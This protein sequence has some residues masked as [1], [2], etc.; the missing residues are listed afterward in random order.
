VT[1]RARSFG[2]VALVTALVSQHRLADAKVQAPPP[3]P[4]ASDQIEVS[5]TELDRCV[6]AATQREFDAAIE[7]CTASVEASADNHRAWYTLGALYG[8]RGKWSEAADAFAR[9]APFDAGDP[10]YQMS[11][12]I[13]LYERDVAQARD[14]T[15][16]REGR[17]AAEVDV[18]LATL[19]FT[20]ARDRL[21]R[22]VA[23]QPKL[24]RAHSYLGRI[25][26]AGGDARAAAAALSRAIEANPRQGASYIAL[27][28]LYRRW[29]YV[30][31][32]VAVATLGTAHVADNAQRSELW[33]ALGLAR[34][35]SKDDAGAIDAY[36]RALE[37]DPAN[38]RA[39]L[40][41]G[42]AAY[43]KGELARAKVDLEA[44][45]KAGGL[46]GVDKV[47][48]NRM[49]LDIAAKQGAKRGK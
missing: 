11:L 27:A 41:R 26:R 39:L 22:A 2:A 29:D 28:E 45:I 14:D 17:P 1:A 5:R 35:V 46:S 31:Q 21:E 20:E 10:M 4:P 9:A 43:R 8:L 36:T 37:D 15:A 25:H 19:N 30:E 47:A 3:A 12:G 49:L 7:A 18:D 24:W 6:R 44:A 23:I 40:Q 48:V 13:A 42:V 16:R 33:V 34:A 32:A 38:R